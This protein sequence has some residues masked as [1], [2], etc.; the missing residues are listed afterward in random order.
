MWLLIQQAVCLAFTCVYRFS[1]RSDA[2][3]IAV[4]LRAGPGSVVIIIQAEFCSRSAAI[5]SAYG[6]PFVSKFRIEDYM[7]I[8]GYIYSDDNYGYLLNIH[9]QAG[10]LL[11]RRQFTSRQF[12]KSHE[13]GE[14]DDTGIATHVD[15]R[16]YCIPTGIY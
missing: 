1:S 7:Q 10:D 5:A 8:G 2:V 3:A 4:R 14:V 6:V 16:I 13:H 11:N 12:S 9:A 15:P